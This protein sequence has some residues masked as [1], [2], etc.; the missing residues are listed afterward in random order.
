[1]SV[2]SSRQR[3]RRASM[4]AIS[5]FQFALVGKVLLGRFAESRHTHHDVIAVRQIAVRDWEPPWMFAEKVQS[6][7]EQLGAFAE[8][9]DEEPLDQAAAAALRRDF[10][11]LVS[12]ARSAAASAWH[13][14]ACRRCR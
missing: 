8:R 11:E 2:L 7:Q 12:E 1:M 10:E 9:L 5:V 13:K 6:L 3:H 4:D 14:Y